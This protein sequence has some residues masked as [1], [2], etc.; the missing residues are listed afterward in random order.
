MHNFLRGKRTNLGEAAQGPQWQSACLVW[1]YLV[2]F[3]AA[4]WLRAVEDP[5]AFYMVMKISK[6]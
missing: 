2:G 4:A 6:V 1:K 3:H 5:T